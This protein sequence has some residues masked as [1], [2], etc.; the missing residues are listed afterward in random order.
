M[1]WV[2]LTPKAKALRR[3]LAAWAIGLATKGEDNI[4]K[5]RRITFR[6]GIPSWIPQGKVVYDQ[7]FT[8]DAGYTLSRS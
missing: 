7:L 1:A 8:G 6:K 5:R 3:R 4:V 2:C